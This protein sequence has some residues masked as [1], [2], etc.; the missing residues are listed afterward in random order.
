MRLVHRDS[1]AGTIDAVDEAFF[2][3]RRLSKSAREQAAKWIAGRQGKPGSYADMFAPTE[4]DFKRGARLFSG[5]T[6]RT[7]AGTAHILGEEACRALILLDVSLAGVRQALGRA[8]AGMMS[9]L[10]K[11]RELASGIYCCGRCSVALWRHLAAGGLET[12]G[13]E[14][15]LTAGMKTLKSHRQGG[16][17]WRRFPFYY[18]LLALSE[19]EL[20]SALREMR[21]AAPTCE[22]FLRRPSRDDPIDRRRRLL[23][24]RVL[25]KC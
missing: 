3:G 19:I 8:S 25:A 23:A 7:R 11:A 18:T 22:R 17:R 24:E 5:E 20:P 6:I 12:V 13:P 9:R 16:G 10:R 15:L 21:Y 4:T 2:L 1:L 14:R